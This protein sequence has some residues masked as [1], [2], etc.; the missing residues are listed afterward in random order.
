MRTPQLQ[1]ACKEGMTTRLQLRLK[2]QGNQP[3]QR[4]L[5]LQQRSLWGFSCHSKAL[6]Q[7][8]HFTG[9][10]PVTFST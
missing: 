6:V 10:W 2:P 5:T 7:T 4:P 9:H 3:Q 1:R 8:G